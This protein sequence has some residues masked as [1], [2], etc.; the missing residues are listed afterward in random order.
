M[1]DYAYPD[2]SGHFGP[3]G[4]SFI[5]ETLS[6]ALEELQAAYDHYKNDPQFLAEYRY[7]LK[8]FVGRPSPVYHA[9]RLSDK[10]GGARIYLKRED[11]N[12]TGA[13]KIN[14]T[15]GQAMLARR[16]GKPRVI[17]ETGAG[18]HGVATATIAARY[19]MECVVYMGSE[20]V[21]RQ[22]PNVYRMN[23]LGA[24]VV[25]VE[26]GSKTLKDALNE[27]LR[28]WVTNV[29]DTFYIIGTVAGPHPYPQMVR[30]F[31]RVIGDECLEQM[32]EMTGRQ[33]DA[34]IAAVGG[35]S[36]AMGIFY[37]YIPHESVRLIGVEAAGLGLDTGKHAA[38]LSAGTPGV[39]H[40]NRTYL[41]QD[42]N[43]QIIETHSVSA[44]LDYPGVGPEHA[45]LKDLGRAEYVGITDDEALAAFHE[46]C[47][48]EGI[49]PALESSHAL[50]HAIKL[51]PQMRP[52]QNIL[53]NLS[54][55]GDKDINTVAEREGV[56]FDTLFAR[57]SGVTK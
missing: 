56:S 19:G 35:G 57:Q 42:A 25:P 11:L 36:N 3:Y 34:V 49:I 9:A 10:L 16:M 24:R 28:D 18:Q 26:S 14:N 22:S 6:H 8:H 45:W 40:G 37:P 48:I 53:V 21:K 20:D 12:H 5:A 29:E 32:P 2:A 27:A 33:P 41:L 51:A 39:L 23:L 1:F 47:R 46:L 38:S 15:I 30:D 52:D 54:G 50:A 31:Q 4:G 7:E 17:A 44:G 13:H 55:R 43:G